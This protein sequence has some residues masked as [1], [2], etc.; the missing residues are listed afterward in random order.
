VAAPVLMA[1][2][3][4][5]RARATVEESKRTLDQALSAAR[6]G[7]W[8]WDIDSG[9]VTWSDNMEGIQRLPSGS[10][11]G[12][13]E[14]F[15]APIH[16]EDRSRVRTAIDRAVSEGGDYDVDFRI[17]P[18]DGAVQWINGRGHVVSR[19]GKPI[20]MV[21]LRT[22]I[23]DRMAGE[24]ARR[25]LAAIVSSSADAIISKDLEGH[26]LSWN[27]AAERL[28]GYREEE[29]L[30]RSIEM[31]HPDGSEDFRT[32]LERVARGERVEHYET[33]RRRKDGSSV[34]VALTVSPILD[35][36]GS[37]I[38]ASKT[39]RDLTAQREAEREHERTRQLFL[40]TLGH[41]LR[42]P[43][44]T[45]VASLYYLHRRA[46]ETL[47]HVVT[48]MS[49][50]AQRMARMIEQLLDFTRARLGQGIPLNPQPCDLREICST[51]VGEIEAE[52]PN[53]LI[54]Q[55][56]GEFTAPW[57]SDRLAQMFSNLLANAIDHG[58]RADPVKVRLSREDGAVRVEVSNR[59]EP[60]PEPLQATIFEPF[61]RGTRERTGS[62]RGLGL[63]LYITREIVRS[64]GGSIDVQSGA[65]ETVFTVRLPVVDTPPD[66]A[67]GFRPLTR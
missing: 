11:T 36:N 66:D 12:G 26:I 2:E 24:Q 48:R 3:A 4:A 25:H 67:G 22:N 54:I 1:V 28:F 5:R 56:D 8:I 7:Y 34:E 59:G 64:H 6:M 32:I 53:R 38:G 42:N 65:G 31:L 60:I 16:P 46:P 23:T 61:R 18:E 39:L 41:D 14:G 20:R 37:V 33:V 62:S 15:L 30:G 52:H 13:I 45:I 43:L 29:V 9:K 17:V 55:A 35:E 44:N 49:G 19:G 27:A 63:G 10:F 21:S 58:S 51:V 57:D 40:A 47:Q 50:S